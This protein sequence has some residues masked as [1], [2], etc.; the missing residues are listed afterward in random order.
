MSEKR[1]PKRIA[2]YIVTLGVLIVLGYFGRGFYHGARTI[3]E[4]LTENK[5]LKQAITN[6]TVEDQIGYAKV[7][8]QEDRDG[9]LFTTIKFVETARDDTLKTVFEKEYTIEG[10]VI[11]FDSLIV[12][13]GEQMVLDGEEKAMYLWRRVYGENTAPGN[14][15][16]IDDA[17]GEPKRYSDL[18]ALLPAG[19]RKLFWTNIWDLANDP[20]KLK[21]YG[22]EAIYGN[23]VYSKLSKG[24][25]YVFKISSAGQLYPQVLPDM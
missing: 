23:V 9:T 5:H 15:Q 21:S 20:D 25:V 13:F 7:I 8:F 18:L 24:F 2:L 16:A 19:Q 6:L 1:K 4:L 17:G 12:K 14:G 22:I 11:H 10:D 3:G